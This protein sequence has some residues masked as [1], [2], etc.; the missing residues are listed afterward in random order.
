MPTVSRAHAILALV[1]TLGVGGR[2]IRSATG[3]EESA[4]AKAP[5]G[6]ADSAP[7]SALAGQI[8][9]VDS[10]RGAKRGSRRGSAGRRVARTSLAEKSTESPSRKKGR[11]SSRA[12]NAD[13]SS[14]GEFAPVAIPPLRQETTPE[15]ALDYGSARTQRAQTSSDRDRGL[16]GARNASGQN[17]R[18]GSRRGANRAPRTHSVDEPPIDLESATAAQI[19][20]LPRVG[21]S[22][23]ARIVAD[24]SARGPFRSIEGFQRV[25]GVGPA[26]VKLLIPHVTFGVNGRPSHAALPS[27]NAVSLE[28]VRSVASRSAIFGSGRTSF[29]ARPPETGG[30]ESFTPAPNGRSTR[31]PLQRH[32]RTPAARWIRQSRTGGAR[33]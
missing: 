23:A 31:Y 21:P 27:G 17:A 10:A 32:R 11:S 2:W 25:R 14:S 4:R 28:L 8:A 20:R 33:A 3:S 7:D 24:R 15:G 18:R 9:K 22:L 30:H 29:T 16:A 26:M 19:E 6:V 5:G 1:V 12:R 13:Q